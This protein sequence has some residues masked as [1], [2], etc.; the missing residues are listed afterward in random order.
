MLLE[1]RR[2][3]EVAKR[4]AEVERQLR[5]TKQLAAEQAKIHSSRPHDLPPY[6]GNSRAI[7]NPPIFDP[8]HTPLRMNATGH[9]SI[10]A[11]RNQT[12]GE[13]LPLPHQPSKRDQ[14]RSVQVTLPT[15][16][17]IP[18]QPG[19]SVLEEKSVSGGST[20]RENS[21]LGKTAL[22][23]NSAHLALA[24][25]QN[26]LAA[27]QLQ[28][29]PAL[30]SSRKLFKGCAID[31]PRFIMEYTRSALQL[32]SN[33]LMCQQILVGLIE[34][35]SLAYKLVQPYFRDPKP[36]KAAE[37]LKNMLEI[38]QMTY[39]TSRKQSRAQLDIL[40]NRPKVSS[41]EEG[42][43]EFYSEL[44]SCLVVMEEC[45]RTNDLDSESTLKD[46]CAK[47]PDYIQNNWVRYKKKLGT[48]TST[49]AQLLHVIKEEHANKLEDINQW[50]EEA[51]SKKK[52]AKG[53]GKPK[54]A[55][56]NQTSVQTHWPAQTSS[57]PWSA[58]AQNQ[59]APFNQHPTCLC[60]PQGRHDCIASCP[61]Y[62][63]AATRQ[64]KWQLIKQ[65][66][67]LCFRCLYAG[68]KANRCPLGA[69]EVPGCEVRHHISLH[70]DK[71]PG[72]SRNQRAPIG[73][74]PP[75]R[76]QGAQ[77]TAAPSPLLPPPV[78][79]QTWTPPAANPAHGEH[80]PPPPPGISNN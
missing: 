39:G 76:M 63:Q 43:I 41:T 32:Q 35:S 17:T 19:Q 75:A 44:K 11:L 15:E 57:G 34:P 73:D 51:R 24:E 27:C 20:T 33:P 64:A 40:R 28:S 31:Y 42:L 6:P 14:R 72:A 48:K 9:T 46:L 13:F 12:S 50:R 54:I 74:N 80:F 8:S 21:L 60:G 1:S 23:E 58:P 66:G 61:T 47:L 56:V 5:L 68:H 22:G 62:I 30:G 59:P 2:T 4:T 67:P 78:V 10:T 70:Y 38:L 77:R 49:Y 16:E 25:R 29:L 26:F 53:D 36:E 55:K 79:G 18:K 52:E 37:G 71:E 69:C 3:A 45:G 7:Q 65:H